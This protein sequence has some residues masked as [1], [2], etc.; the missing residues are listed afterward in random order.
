MRHRKASTATPTPRDAAPKTFRRRLQKLDIFEKVQQEDQIQTSTGGV[1]TL[2]TYIIMTILF[3]SEFSAY[4]TT[5]MTEHVKVDPSAGGWLQINVNVTFKALN[6]REVSLVAMDVAGEHQLGIAHTIHKHRLDKKGRTIGERFKSSLGKAAQAREEGDAWGGMDGKKL[7]PL[8]PNYCGACYGAG[9]KGQCCNTCD[10]VRSAYD[11]KGWSTDQLD[12][13]SEQCQRE[14]EAGGASAAKVGEGCNIEGNLMVNK[15]AGNIHVALGKS[16]S[17]NGRLIHQFS[18]R[19]LEHFDTS[20]TIHTLSFGDTFPGQTNALDGVEKR[21][22][23]H[24]SHTGVYQYYVKIIPTQFTTSRGVVTE[25]NQYSFTEKFVPVGDADEEEEE[26]VKKPGEEG[27][28]VQPHLSRGNL[29][30]HHSIIRAL[31]GVFFIYEMSPFMVLRTEETVGL[32]HFLVRVCAVIGG[33]FTTSS[34]ISRFVSFLMTGGKARESGSMDVF[35][36]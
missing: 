12:V 19:Q 4:M 17:V 29:H 32:P 26:I 1:Q 8:P 18:P 31:P 5:T 28:S 15:V 22:N 6:C 23:H 20:H 3:L 13:T 9:T 14:N 35:G 16:K 25:S 10:E 21:V 27:K 36:R 30:R 24:K 33:V 11:T 7:K 34:L 2:L